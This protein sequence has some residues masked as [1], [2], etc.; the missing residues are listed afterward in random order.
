MRLRVGGLPIKVVTAMI[1]AT[2]GPVT[3]W[4]V[5]GPGTAANLGARSMTAQQARGTAIL[6]GQQRVPG[7]LR[8]ATSKMGGGILTFA[9]S[10]V[11]DARQS[12]EGPGQPG[13]VN[14]VPFHKYSSA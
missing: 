14:S 3:Q 13:C 5:T 4:R 8:L 1:P 7:V 10:V 11:M 2:G 12:V 6:A 9:P